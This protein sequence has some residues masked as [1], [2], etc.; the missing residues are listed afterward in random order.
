MALPAFRSPYAGGFFEAA[1]PESSPLPWPSR[2]LKRSAPACSPCGANMSTLQDSLDGT[3]YWVALPSQEDTALH[4]PQS[5]GSSGGLLRGSLAITTTGLPPVSH[6]DLS[7]RTKLLLGARLP[8]PA[9]TLPQRREIT[10][11]VHKR[12]DEHAISRD[13]IDES[14]APNEQLAKIR[15]IAFR[16]HPPTLSKS[17]QRP[18]G[19]PSLLHKC[20]GIEARIPADERRGLFQILYGGFRPS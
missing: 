13:L 9:T 8:W 14:I 17:S 15:C 6:Q 16:H 2:S 5:P 12:Q 19:C 1:L 4:H 18:G 20:C 7:R 3:D 11:T 10:S